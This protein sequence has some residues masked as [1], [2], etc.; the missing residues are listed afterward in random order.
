MYSAVILMAPRVLGSVSRNHLEPTAFWGDGY[1]SIGISWNLV[2]LYVFVKALYVS[3]S[4]HASSKRI[5]YVC[6][7]SFIS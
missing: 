3:R 5:L 2:S 6:M 7:V 4:A 1:G